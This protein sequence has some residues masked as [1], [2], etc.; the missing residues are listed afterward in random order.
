MDGPLIHRSAVG[1]TVRV[2]LLGGFRLLAR[3]DV[4]PVSGGA[5]RLLAFVALH[6]QPVG[7]LLVAGTLW[8]DVSKD[9]AY[10]TLRAALA[11][12]DRAGRGCCASLR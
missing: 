10:A 3:N 2:A 9:R 1:V 4:V 8:P 12:L 7:R 6:D 5:E 11:R